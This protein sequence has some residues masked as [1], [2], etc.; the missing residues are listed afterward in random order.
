MCSQGTDGDVTRSPQLLKIMKS[1]Y[2]RT[3]QYSYR[4]E[5]IR[6]TV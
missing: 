5:V 1:K 6:G 4:I 2:A 3:I